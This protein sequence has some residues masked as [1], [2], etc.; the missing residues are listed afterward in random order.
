MVRTLISISPE[1]KRWLDR[2]AK[3][4]HVSMSRLVRSGIH[5]LMGQG[6]PGEGSFEDRLKRT[7]GLWKAGDGLAYQQKMRASWDRVPQK[8]KA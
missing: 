3:R 2:Q 5:L 7:S 6:V 4:E 1:E 8:R